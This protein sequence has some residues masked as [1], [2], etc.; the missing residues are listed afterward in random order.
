MGIGTLLEGKYKEAICPVESNLVKHLRMNFCLLHLLE[1]LAY[2]LYAALSRHDRN[3]EI[4][5]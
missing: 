3:R 1:G 2:G 4:S 5:Q